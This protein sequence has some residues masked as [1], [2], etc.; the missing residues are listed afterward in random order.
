VPPLSVQPAGVPPEL[1]AL[2]LELLEELEV[3]E[4]ELEVLEELALLL[5]ELELL[6][7]ELEPPAPVPPQPNMAMTGAATTTDP[8]AFTKRLRDAS[9]A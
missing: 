1:E 3:L 6:L 9:G 2:E 5:E 7:D 8:S 4:E